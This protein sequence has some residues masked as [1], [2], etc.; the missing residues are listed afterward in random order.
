MCTYRIS[1]NIVKKSYLMFF[2]QNEF[3][4]LQHVLKYTKNNNDNIFSFEHIEWFYLCRPGWDE[5]KIGKNKE[6]GVL[7]KF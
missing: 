2:G 6:C 1:Y 7:F 5:S 4:L 3:P